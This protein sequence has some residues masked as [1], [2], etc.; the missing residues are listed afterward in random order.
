MPNPFAHIELNTDDLDQAT[1]FYQAVFAWKLRPMPE[2]NYTMIDAGAQPG[3]GMQKRMMPSQP[4]GWLPY[5]QVDDVKKTVAKAAKAGAKVILEYMSIGEMGAI[6]VFEDPT[7]YPIGVWEGKAAAPP[8]APKKAAK[9][10]AKKAAKKVEKVAP[11]VEK[12]AKKAAKKA[13]KKR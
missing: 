7:G 2:M 6:G 12:V 10:V 5:V 1:K 13:A 11:K 9:K 4:K 8:P 3:G